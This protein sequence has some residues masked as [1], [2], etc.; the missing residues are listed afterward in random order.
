MSVLSRNRIWEINWTPSNS[1]IFSF[2]LPFFLI[3]LQ[4]WSDQKHKE[5]TNI[6][7]SRNLFQF[8]RL[9]SPEPH[10]VCLSVRV[11]VISAVSGV[12]GSNEKQKTKSGPTY[13]LNLQLETF[14]LDMNW[15]RRIIRIFLKKKR[16]KGEWC[17]PKTEFFFYKLFDRKKIKNWD[18][19]IIK[20]NR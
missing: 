14:Y 6:N 19:K 13:F 12:R 17:R 11:S 16:R 3:Y 10:Y 15:N 5:H 7:N 1:R 20:T 9:E 2:Y 8:L 4:Y 18:V